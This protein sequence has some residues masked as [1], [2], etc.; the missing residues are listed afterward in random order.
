MREIEQHWKLCI[1]E[2][3]NLSRIDINGMNIDFNLPSDYFNLSDREAD[4]ISLIGRKYDFI[5]QLVVMNNVD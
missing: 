3:F 5:S 4:K 2:Q 1:Q